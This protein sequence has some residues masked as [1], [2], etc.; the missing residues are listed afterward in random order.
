MLLKVYVVYL[1]YGYSVTNTDLLAIQC[2]PRAFGALSEV[3][4]NILDK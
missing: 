4:V 3:A 2:Y 1:L